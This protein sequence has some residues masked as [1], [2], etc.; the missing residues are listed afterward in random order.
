MKYKVTTLRTDGTRGCGTFESLHF[1]EKFFASRMNSN[2]VS[3][4]LW[5]GEKPI[6][7]AESIG[8]KWGVIDIK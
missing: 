6:R 1:A 2:F 4:I 5:E 7:Y 3:I 8:L